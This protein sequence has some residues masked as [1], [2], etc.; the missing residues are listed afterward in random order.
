M[1]S[2][3][4]VRKERLDYG[5]NGLKTMMIAMPTMSV[6][7]I[8]RLGVVVVVAFNQTYDCFTFFV[9]FFFVVFVLLLFL[10]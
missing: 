6:T 8:N 5:R 7:T 3:M 4:I 1:V 9:L 2:R 10:L